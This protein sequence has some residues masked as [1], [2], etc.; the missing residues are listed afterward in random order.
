VVG[1]FSIASFTKIASDN[2]LERAEDWFVDGS[3]R[4]GFDMRLN[5]ATAGADPHETGALKI[6][7]MATGITNR[8]TRCASEL[9]WW[10]I[11]LKFT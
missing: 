3:R 7:K 8:L 4:D 2:A 9:T 5:C 6:V 11:L 1:T 10:N